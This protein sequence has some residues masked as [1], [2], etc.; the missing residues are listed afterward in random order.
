MVNLVCKCGGGPLS[1]PPSSIPL[2]LLRSF[3][4]SAHSLFQNFWL[5]ACILRWFFTV[6][7]K[8]QIGQ[9][10]ELMGMETK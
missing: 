1:F 7:N 6:M 5:Q 4:P 9:G 8:V 2:S 3:L 10:K